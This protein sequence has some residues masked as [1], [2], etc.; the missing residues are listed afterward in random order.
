[1]RHDVR[2]LGPLAVGWFALPLGPLSPIGIAVALVLAA[3]GGD[4]APSPSTSGSAA[5]SSAPAPA[6][7]TREPARARAT[8]TQPLVAYDTATLPAGT[9]TVGS[10]PEEVGRDDDELQHT[11][12]LTRAVLV[13]KTEVTQA[14]WDSVMESNP[15]RRLDPALP[16]DQV[17]WYDALVF[18]NALSA[19]DGLTPA[20]TVDGTAVTYDPSATGWRLPTE[21]EWEI[22]AR[23][24]AD[25]AYSGGS[26]AN[27]VAWHEGNADGGSHKPC[28]KAPNALGICDMS[29]N[30]LEWVWDRYADYPTGTV[31]DPRGPDAGD[32]SRINRGGSWSYAPD[33][34]RVANRNRGVPAVR[35]VV[36]GLRLVRNA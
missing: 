12:V 28:T 10:P 13:G 14:L 25:G 35:F 32:N 23:G 1:M 6:K 27:A 3:C 8:P 36:L 4:G 29:G 31:T 11:V 15:S 20:Y 24:G 18:A 16:V 5:S 30:V 21:A 34:A 7:A 9:Y 26:E 33:Y 2:A 22:A 19:R 17:S